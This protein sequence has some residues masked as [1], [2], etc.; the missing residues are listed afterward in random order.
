AN[1]MILGIEAGI[2]D[3]LYDQ[4][5]ATGTSHVIVISGSNVALIAGV[6]MALMV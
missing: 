1:G 6:I 3:D 2:P 4:F 5:N